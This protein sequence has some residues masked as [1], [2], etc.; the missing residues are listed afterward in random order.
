MY[1]ISQENNAVINLDKVDYF[2]VCE[3]L[4]RYIVYANCGNSYCE[5]ASFDTK[6]DAEYYLKNT[7]IGLLINQGCDVRGY[8][9]NRDWE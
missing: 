9:G 2:D 8:E 3:G 1:L 4:K 7:I 5:I 6:E